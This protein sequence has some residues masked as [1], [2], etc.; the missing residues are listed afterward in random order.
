ML[1][2]DLVHFRA[3]LSNGV[4]HDLILSP[5]TANT[6]PAV[7][8]RN[9][10]AASNT[11]DNRSIASQDDHHKKHTKTKKRHWWS[12]PTP[13]VKAANCGAGMKLPMNVV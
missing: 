8:R 7:S 6:T 12:R 11:P 4:S 5:S 13:S 2:G 3:A 9:S 10:T 1:V